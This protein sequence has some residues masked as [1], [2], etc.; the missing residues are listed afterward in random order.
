[1]LKITLSV[2]LDYHQESVQVCVMDASGKVLANRSVP[3]L[4]RAIVRVVRE[5]LS[6]LPE[7]TVCVQAA[8]ESCCGAAHLGEELREQ[9]QWEVT[10]AH[11]GTVNRMKQNRD[12]TDRSDAWILADLTR[13]GYLP[14]VWLAPHQ[15]RE[16]RAIVRYRGQRVA[17]RRTAKL[18]IRAILRENR[19]RPPEGINAWTRAWCAW[20]KQ[21][22]EELGQESRWVLDQHLADLERISRAIQ[23]VERRLEEL[24]SS[25]AVVTKLRTLPGIG[26]ITAVVMRAEIAHFDRFR[27]GKQLARFCGVSPRNASSGTRQADAGLIRAG[28]PYLRATLIEAAQRLIQRDPRWSGLAARL[29]K[30][31]KPHNVIVAAVANRWMRWLHHQLQPEHLMAS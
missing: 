9:A 31:G 2:G 21:V 29:K 30:R 26:L 5:V 12:K 17:E 22:R 13:L 27:T 25:D 18:R 24:T 11:P 4:W 1:M 8:L 20:L 15:V 3:N 10:L 6:E 14:R 16:L 7:G 28:N 19:L 23:E